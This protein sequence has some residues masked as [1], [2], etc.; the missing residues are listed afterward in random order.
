MNPGFRF[1]LPDIGRTS[2]RNGPRSHS[3]RSTHMA[4][5][6]GAA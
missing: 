1:V 6:A 3:G 4:I 5:Q 2:R